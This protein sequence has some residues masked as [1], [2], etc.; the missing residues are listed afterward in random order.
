MKTQALSNLHEKV[1]LWAVARGSWLVLAA[2]IMLALVKAVPIYFERAQRI[3]T[4]GPA[5]CTQLALLTVERLHQLEALGI[6]LSAWAAYILISRLILNA[7]FGLV[8]LLIFLRKPKERMALFVA[9]FLLAFGA[10]NGVINALGQSSA[11]WWLPVQFITASGW[12]SFLIFF[13][14]FPSGHFVPRWISWVVIVFVGLLF[15]GIFFP[16]TPLDIGNSLPW[17]ASIAFPTMF[18]SMLGAQVYRYRRVSTPVERQQTKWVVYGVAMMFILAIVFTLPMLFRST[19][20]QSTFVF[21]LSGG[22]GNLIFLLLPLS[23]GMAMLRSRLW[24]IDVLINRTLVYGILTLGIGAA[25]VLLVGSLSNLLGTQGNLW[26]S[27]LV[28]G[29][30]AVLFQP[31]RERLQ[32]AVNRSMY[33]QRDDPYAVLA[34]LSS[35]LETSLAP[36]AVLPA[37]VETTALALKLPY[38]A[39]HLGRGESQTLGA[40]YP[41][42]SVIAQQVKNHICFPIDYQ[43]ESLGELVITSR[44][45]D[46]PLTEPDQRLL[47]DLVRQA[48]MAI[49]AVRLSIDLQHAREQ[50]VLALE[51]ERRRLRRDLHDGL[52]PLLANVTML[53]ETAR[54]LYARDPI[55]AEGLLNKAVGQT[56]VA[57]E[58]IRRLVNN[59]RPPALDELGL[60]GALREQIAGYEHSGIQFHFTAPESLPILPAALEVATYRITQEA[61]NN[62]ARH[63]QA[64]QCDISLTLA[65]MLELNIWDNGSGIPVEYSAGVGLHSMRE[66]A[67]ELGGIFIIERLEQGTRILVQLPL[68]KVG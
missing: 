38:A 68:Q 22:L 66:R 56:Q 23:I 27:L 53:A 18:A 57:I 60:T 63:A 29:L 67:A 34:R 52:G 42:H 6:S 45:P 37:L 33:G 65:E 12:A 43:G 51:E 61:I 20:S 15:L 39:I 1:S 24:D 3:C 19:Y 64:S 35:R 21:I 28:T 55:H 2:F 9:F 32:R 44:A 17:F 59:L 54:D 7:V 26:I 25:Y 31:L 50:L 30:I 41:T 40:E 46:E 16:G 13:T 10:N 4:L 8:A 47:G 58:D 48:G 49:H 62:V 14:H 11:A 36:D 5:E